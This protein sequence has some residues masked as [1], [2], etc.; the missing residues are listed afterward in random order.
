ML[1]LLISVLRMILV[2]STGKSQFKIFEILRTRISNT[3][4]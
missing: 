1:Y 4:G 2:S 3:F